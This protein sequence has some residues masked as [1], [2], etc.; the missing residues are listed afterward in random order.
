MASKLST[1]RKSKF[2]CVAAVALC[3]CK[4]FCKVLSVK[5]RVG[6]LVEKEDDGDDD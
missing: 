5:V 1:E 2:F 4:I 3:H 6:P